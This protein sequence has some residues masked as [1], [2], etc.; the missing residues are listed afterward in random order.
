M[1]AS[2]SGLGSSYRRCVRRHDG[3]AGLRLGGDA[4]VRQRHRLCRTPFYRIFALA[5]D[6]GKV[7]WTFDSNSP[8]K[9]HTQGDLKTRGVAYWQA[10][11]RRRPACQKI[12]YIGTMDAKLYAVDADNGK[13]CT[14]FGDNGVLD[15]NQWNMV[16]DKWPLSILQPPTVYKNQLFIGWA[17]Q[18]WA[19][20]RCSLRAPSSPSMP[21]PASSTG[22]SMPCRRTSTPRPAPPT[23]GR[24]CRSTRKQHPVTCR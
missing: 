11:P 12:V 18:D 3:K 13:A 9:A 19:T 5:P 22:S 4:A 21:R 15:I 24:R 6:T 23:S 7:K 1:S 2:S 14:G 8:L 10:S 20:K 17:G 16:N